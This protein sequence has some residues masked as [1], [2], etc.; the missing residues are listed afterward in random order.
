MGAGR[1]GDVPFARAGARQ[2]RAPGFAILCLALTALAGPAGVAAAESLGEA[3]EETKLMMNW[4]LRYEGVDQAGLPEQADALTSRVRAGFETGSW[5]ATSLLGELAWTEDVVDDF[6][7]T[8]NGQSEY[9]VVADPGGFVDVNRFA[10][11][12]RSLERTQL[13]LGRQRIVLDDSRFVGNVG[14][15]QNEQTYD[16]VRVEIDAGGAGSGAGAADARVHVDVAYIDQVNRIFGPDSPAGEW[17]GAIVL[18]NVSK[19]FAWGKLT[20][21]AYGLD[22]DEAAALSSD[23]VG[24]RLAGSR[25]AGDLTALYTLSIARQTDAGASPLD[26]AETYFLAEG[27]LRVSK[28]TLA[29][30]VEQLSSDGIASVTTPLATLHAFQGWADKFLTT[31]AAGVDDRF[32]RVAYQPGARGP[33]ESLSIVGVYHVLDA[34]FG[35]AHYGD[36]L[37]VSVAAGFGKLTFTLKYAAYEADELFTDTD[38]LWLSLDYAF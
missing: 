34:D 21:F 33:F 22:I 23:T 35:S 5:G 15:R 7:S 16:G 9:P 20:G 10:L 29:L 14:W 36:E 38:K 31:P 8:T 2:P 18:A 12:N 1:P 24:L 30:G 6:N 4:R 11:T 19:S 25:P 28:V 17:E 3:L 27:G 13:T 37:D 32:V 26:Y